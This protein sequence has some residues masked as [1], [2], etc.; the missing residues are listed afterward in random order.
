M[1]SNTEDEDIEMVRVV[2][3]AIHQ[4]MDRGNR[5]GDRSIERL[6]LAAILAMT[7]WARSHPRRKN[8]N[9]MVH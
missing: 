5:T 7:R 2:A 4:E 1:F 3:Q 9:G 6:A 8:D